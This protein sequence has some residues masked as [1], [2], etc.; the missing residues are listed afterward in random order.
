M[1]RD[2]RGNDHNTIQ[3][4]IVSS[5]LW[6]IMGLAVPMLLVQLSPQ[7]MTPRFL[8]CSNVWL[9]S[10]W[11]WRAANDDLEC[12]SKDFFASTVMLLVQGIVFGNAKVC[13]PLN[14]DGDQ[15]C[16]Q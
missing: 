16:G 3:S 15:T 10:I 13:V 11:A 12:Y 14:P 2:L 9:A 4:L 1:G 5:E 6:E 8:D 7:L